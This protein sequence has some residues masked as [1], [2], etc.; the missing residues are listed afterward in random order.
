MAPASTHALRPAGRLVCSGTGC[1]CDGG[2]A[3]DWSL[4][5]GEGP[6]WFSGGV[7]DIIWRPYRRTPAVRNPQCHPISSGSP[8]LASSA[9]A[10]SFRAAT[11]ASAGVDVH[12][13]AG[14]VAGVHLPRAADLGGRVVDHLPPLG[15]PARCAPDGEQRGE[16]VRREA[17]R[18]VDQ[19]G[20]EVDVR[21]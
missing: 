2:P 19:A 9:E 20:V 17:H 4:P 15:D 5:S 11:G 13:V 10:G 14:G 16:H 18:L 12:V 8:V 6:P 7:A 3:S 1:W 21:V